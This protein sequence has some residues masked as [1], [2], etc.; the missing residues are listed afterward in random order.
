MKTWYI[1]VYLNFTCLINRKGKKAYC[2]FNLAILPCS[3]QLVFEILNFEFVW[4][5]SISHRPKT[6]GNNDAWSCSYLCNSDIP[7]QHDHCLVLCIL[8]KLWSFYLCYF[9]DPVLY[10]L[11]LWT[12]LYYSIRSVIDCINQVHNKLLTLL[13]VILEFGALI[14]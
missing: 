6:A 11:M 2:F 12:K 14:W 4:Q 1:H 5:H 10:F 3:F 8:C 13:A 7:C 9:I